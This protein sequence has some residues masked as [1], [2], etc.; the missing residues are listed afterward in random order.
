MET[1]ACPQ[2]TS[3]EVAFECLQNALYAAPR[4]NPEHVVSLS[5]LGACCLRR[6]K[7]VIAMRY[8][9]RA[10]ACDEIFEREFRARLRL[11][12]CAAHNQLGN[13]NEALMQARAPNA[14]H[15]P[16]QQGCDSTP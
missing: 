5:N 2:D 15:G 12:L 8:L 13:H 10:I 14:R 3:P 6:G 7:P 1:H 16:Q 11:N 4:A 9:Q